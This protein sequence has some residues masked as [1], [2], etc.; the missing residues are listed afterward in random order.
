MQQEQQK[1]SLVRIIGT[2]IVGIILLILVPFLGP[3]PGPGGIPLL[4]TGLGLLAS[5]HAFARR[6]LLYVKKHSDSLRE[7]AFPNITWIMWAWDGLAVI[8]MV[9]GIWVSVSADSVF[10]KGLSVSAMAS[11]TTILLLNR[12][13][14]DY[15]EKKFLKK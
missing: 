11:S 7:I 4:L 12:N 9:G 1:K 13:R 15:F 6:W 3:I 10:L 14:S 5:N 2:D 8:L